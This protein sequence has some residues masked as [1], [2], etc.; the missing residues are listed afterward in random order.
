MHASFK[1][2]GH[3]LYDEH[4]S[5]SWSQM[6]P[7]KKWVTPQ[8]KKISSLYSQPSNSHVDQ[9][10]TCA[11]DPPHMCSTKFFFPPKQHSSLMEGGSS[12]NNLVV[13]LIVGHLI[14]NGLVW[15]PN[16]QKESKRPWDVKPNGHNMYY[17][18]ISLV[19]KNCILMFYPS[20]Y[21]RSPCV[22]NMVSERVPS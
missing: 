10:L 7:T 20:H 17:K 22:F 14:L 11:M 12:I 8:E 2:M 6:L 5:L 21:S 13:F 18:F 3:M 16:G 4:T 19:N 1:Y 9:Q 15:K